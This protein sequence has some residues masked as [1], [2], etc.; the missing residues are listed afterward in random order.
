MQ[1]GTTQI[2]ANLFTKALLYLH[3][4]KMYSPMTIISTKTEQLTGLPTPELPAKMGV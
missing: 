4:M 2:N 1:I 3:L